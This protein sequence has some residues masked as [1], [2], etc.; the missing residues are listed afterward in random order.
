[1]HLGMNVKKAKALYFR[2]I[3]S[4]RNIGILDI[5]Y[6]IDPNSQFIHIEVNAAT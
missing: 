5:S 6:W 1:M 2:G 4:P 3:S